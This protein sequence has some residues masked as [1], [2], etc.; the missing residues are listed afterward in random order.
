MAI[1]S[2][3]L[4]LAEK[5][6]IRVNLSNESSKRLPPINIVEKSPAP[7][8]LLNAAVLHKPSSAFYDVIDIE[9]QSR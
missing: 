5:L 9:K 7:I 2:T 6:N 3:L 1:L 8:L 4:I